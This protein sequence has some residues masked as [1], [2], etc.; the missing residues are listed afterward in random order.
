FPIMSEPFKAPSSLLIIGSGVFGLSTA[1][2]LTKRP[3]WASTAITILDRTPDFPS[4]D[5]SSIDS[6]RII[7]ADYAD[8]AYASLA[9]TAWEEWRRPG[10]DQ[11]GGQGRYTESGFLIVADQAPLV[12]KDG[13]KT[14]MG[15]TKAAYENTLQI[16]KKEGREESFVQVVEGKEAIA[17][18]SGT[19]AG[20]GDWGYLNKAAGWADAEASMNWLYNKVV[21]TGR[22]KF[23]TGTVE[24]LETEGKRV[25]GAKLKDGSSVTAELVMLAAGAW[26]PSLIDL[27]GR[28]VATAQILLYMSITDEEQEKLGKNPVLMNMSRGTFLIT[29]AKNIL[30]IGFHSYGY[31]NPQK[32]STA[33][34]VPKDGV[35]TPT[36]ITVSQPHTHLNDP[37]LWVP[38]EGERIARQGLRSMV[39]WPSVRDRPWTGSRTCWYTDTPT[40]DF[41]IT[42]HPYWEGLFV[43]TGGSG[44]GFKFLPVLGDKIAD[45]IMNK[46][47]TEFQD[48]WGWQ[49]TVNV[50][51][52]ILTEDGS[53]SGRLGLLLHE[54]L[55]KQGP[56]M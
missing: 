2:A 25:T 15:F 48:K 40:G 16:A 9:A 36:E 51:R 24:R 54:E 52:V 8:A 23:V 21:D 44:H 5:S 35:P 27:R 46:C 4:K 50:E 12:R 32:A 41:L 13:I 7:R 56:R 42:Y 49:D 11:I 20:F 14:G 18:A 55:R 38:A 34:V 53:R 29:P 10:A 45:C 22:V 43:A 30:K 26:T 28:V 39:P 31:Q 33:L 37:N 17:K 3:E 19:D 6:S 1:Y 47:P